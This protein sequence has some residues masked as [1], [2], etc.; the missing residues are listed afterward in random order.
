[1]DPWDTEMNKTRSQPYMS[2]QASK[3]KGLLLGTHSTCSSI[4]LKSIKNE[5]IDPMLSELVDSVPELKTQ[6]HQNVEAAFT[7]RLTH[8]RAVIMV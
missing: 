3:T 7:F 5:K 4:F 1:M 2:L 8:H 6:L